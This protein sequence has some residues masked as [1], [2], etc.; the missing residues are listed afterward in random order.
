[1]REAERTYTPPHRPDFLRASLR[2]DGGAGLAS[3]IAGKAASRG[4]LQAIKEDQRPCEEV[5]LQEKPPLEVLC[6][7]SSPDVSPGLCSEE[8]AE[9]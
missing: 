8:P 1:M 5:K 7:V 6:A 9:L 3:A 4:A 2:R